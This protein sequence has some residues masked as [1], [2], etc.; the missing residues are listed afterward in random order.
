MKRCFN[1][2][3]L[4]FNTF[5]Q[6]CVLEKQ[7]KSKEE[8]LP[9]THTLIPFALKQFILQIWIC[10]LLPFHSEKGNLLPGQ[11]ASSV[12]HLPASTKYSPEK[13]FPLAWKS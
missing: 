9:H 2:S 6:L 13:C 11:P 1:C 8:N 5:Q 4:C 12:V 7:T 3:P 10:S